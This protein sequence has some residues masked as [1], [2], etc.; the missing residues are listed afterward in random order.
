MLHAYAMYAVQLMYNGGK[1]CT[2]LNDSRLTFV[3]PNVT[4]FLSGSVLKPEVVPIVVPVSLFW[5][6]CMAFKGAG[7]RH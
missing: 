5:A 3:N 4:E 6:L 7:Q 2:T 1:V